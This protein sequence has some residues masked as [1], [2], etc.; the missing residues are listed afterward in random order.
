M[1][2]NQAPPVREGGAFYCKWYLNCKMKI[3]K[4]CILVLLLVVCH[5][6]LKA[7]PGTGYLQNTV[8]DSIALNNTGIR[9]ATLVKKFYSING[10]NRVWFNNENNY[11]RD[12]LISLLSS[13]AGVGLVESDYHFTFINNYKTGRIKLVSLQDSVNTD[14]LF[15]AAALH[16]FNDVA[17]GNKLPA[18]AYDALHFA[19]S[20]YNVPQ[21]LQSHLQSNTL[22]LFITELGNGLPVINAIVFHLQKM[23]KIV[24][25][26][27]F[28]ETF[29]TD[30]KVAV[31]NVPLVNKLY[32]SGFL[33]S[34][35]SITDSLLK[36]KVKEAQQ[37]FDLLNDGII[38]SA[39]LQ[40]LN[41]PLQVR[42]NQLVTALNNYRWLHGLIQQQKVIVANIPGAY[43]QVYQGDS[44]IL[45]M[46]LIVGKKTTPTPTLL[47]VANEVVL[48]PYWHV[49]YSITTKEL[50]PLIKR[51]IA[52]LEKGNYQVLTRQGKVLNPYKI[53]WRRFSNKYFPYIIRQST[54]CDNSLGLLKLNFYNPFNVY[55]HDTPSAALFGTKKRFYSHGCMRMEKP[56]E[57][58]HLL[59]KDNS[60]AIDTL[61]EKGCVLNQVPVMVTVKEKIPV[62]VWY[63]PVALNAAGRLVFYEDIYER[64]LQK[65]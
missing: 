30:K 65:K 44:V 57:L 53:N 33:D 20:V 12:T 37:S 43:L 3:Y 15:S 2:C 8:Q 4:N 11:Q 17:Y 6:V 40:E 35:I 26:N 59:L 54:G 28:S 9:Y 46:K 38:R 50:L 25:K 18:L 58:G 62:L 41:V 29:V 32:Q 7:Q 24:A 52:F 42:M 45:E 14:I 5:S 16:F 55:L 47:S 39:F 21:L 34:V 19:P 13:A 10:Y 61:E 31:S 60:V 48:Y 22:S 51:D 56:F 63:N 49:P 1:S 64:F 27:N 36:K 23:Q